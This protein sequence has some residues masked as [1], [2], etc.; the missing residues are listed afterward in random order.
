MTIDE[1]SLMNDNSMSLTTLPT[2]HTDH[3]M[4]DFVKPKL[5]GSRKEFSNR[6][7]NPITNGQC[8]DSTPAD[9]RIMKRRAHVLHE[10][11]AGCVQVSMP[12]LMTSV[13]TSVIISIRYN[14]LVES[15][16]IVG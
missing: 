3:C 13:M 1:H 8:A 10:K 14:V 6:F 16:D 4:V 5:L 7:V 9:V 15:T 11:L 12:S 2:P